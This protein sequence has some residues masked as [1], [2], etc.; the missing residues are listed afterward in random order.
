MAAPAAS[1]RYPNS[2]L[3]TCYKGRLLMAVSV[4]EVDTKLAPKVKPIVPCSDP[5]SEMY[6]T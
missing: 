4:Q 5:D 2:S 1:G 6:V 3:E